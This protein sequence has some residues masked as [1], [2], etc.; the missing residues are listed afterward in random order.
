MEVAAF[1]LDVHSVTNAD[2]LPFVE[3]G[4]VEPPAFW[5]KQD[6]QW[7]WRGMFENI[8]LPPAWPVYVAPGGCRGLRAGRRA[9]GS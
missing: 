5:V 7:Y 8:P 6:G 3:A 1:T 4:H 2:Y 9:A